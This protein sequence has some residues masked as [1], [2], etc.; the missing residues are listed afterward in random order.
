M[1][2]FPDCMGVQSR[3]VGKSFRE[4]QDLR[5]SGVMGRGTVLLPREGRGHPRLSLR[6]PTCF[7]ESALPPFYLC[8]PGF[9]VLR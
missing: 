3:F 6:V 2:E 7:L 5:N 1:G 4:K 9:V 8:R